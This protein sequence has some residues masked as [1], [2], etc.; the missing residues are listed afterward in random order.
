MVPTFGKQ[1][2][3]DI[4]VSLVLLQVTVVKF[5]VGFE[6]M[7]GDKAVIRVI[8]VHRV[9]FVHYVQKYLSVKIL[10]Y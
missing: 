9:Q 2:V 1:K 7:I 8:P 6:C 10:R 5:G 4:L 3:R